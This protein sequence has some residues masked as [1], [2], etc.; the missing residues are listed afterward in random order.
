MPLN[1]MQKDPTKGSLHGTFKR[2]VATWA[3]TRRC[4]YPQALTKCSGDL[5]LARSKERR[6]TLPSITTTPSSCL[7]NPAMNR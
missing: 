1:V 5:P 4:W 2:A 7:L 3:S 6:R